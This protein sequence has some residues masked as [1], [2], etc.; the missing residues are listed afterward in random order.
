MWLISSV[1]LPLH[2]VVQEFSP[3]WLILAQPEPATS[4]GQRLL[5]TAGQSLLPP[6]CSF[7]G[8][9]DVRELE[10]PQCQVKDPDTFP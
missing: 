2:W 4:F 7:G 5:P 1:C 8:H 10:Q 6:R 3:A 9:R